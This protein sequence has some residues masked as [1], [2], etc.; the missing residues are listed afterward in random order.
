[1]NDREKLI[2]EA[3]KAAHE[4]QRQKY[5]PHWESLAPYI[6]DA[7]RGRIAAA[8]VV[9]EKARGEAT[10]TPTDRYVVKRRRMFEGTEVTGV[11]THPLS[12]DAAI[13]MLSSFNAEYQDP[14]NY[15]I[16]KWDEK[17]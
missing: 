15:Y 14:G 9:F 5:R 2:E 13:S 8:W 1:M 11:L 4:S 6:Q 12:A 10:F 7:E 3:A 16:E 17:S